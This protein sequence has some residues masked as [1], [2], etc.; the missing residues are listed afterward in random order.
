MDAVDSLE[1]PLSLEL[2]RLIPPLSREV[3]LFPPPPA[4]AREESL[5]F[6][7]SR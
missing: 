2:E 3:D 1:D 6:D 5:E 7:L 4:A